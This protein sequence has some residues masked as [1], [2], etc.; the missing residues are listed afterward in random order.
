MKKQQR[1]GFTLVE[2]LV[3]ISIIGMLAGM[4]LP[5]INAARE[6]GRRAT[7]M[8][9]QRQVALALLNYENTKGAFPP[10]RGQVYS[11]V[12]ITIN[13]TWAGYILPLME[14]NQA[15]ERLT[16]GVTTDVATMPIPILRCRSAARDTTDTR[17]EYV[18]NGGYQNAW[19]KD[20]ETAPTTTYYDPGNRDEA[21]F[22]DHLANRGIVYA[23]NPCRSSVSVEFIS[24][25]SGTSYTILL[26]EN[27]NAGSWYT[28]TDDQIEK[29][30][31]F[32]FPY[33][34]DPKLDPTTAGW[35]QPWAGYGASD[36]THSWKGYEAAN[37]PFNPNSSTISQAPLFINVGRTTIGSGHEQ[38]RFAR[39]SSNHPGTV[40][41]AFADLSTRTLNENMEK[42]TFINICRPN[43]GAIIDW[44]KL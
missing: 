36:A 8:S 30:V 43:S 24:T 5:A 2:L 22:F 15:W 17:M 28:A 44:N 9:N 7:C 26:S 10:M 19:A 14:Y 35:E 13:A 32:C 1:Y 12:T 11:E 33:N 31:A 29:W 27:I 38:Y 4:L 42:G 39:P 18:V 40:V 25:H 3:V 6:A 20:W 21:V 41:A 34:I 37:A 23:D 16:R